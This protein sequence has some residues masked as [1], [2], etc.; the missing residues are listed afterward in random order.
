M[1][2]FHTTDP[3]SGYSDSCPVAVLKARLTVKYSIT[4]PR[5]RIRLLTRHCPT[6]GVIPLRQWIFE[7]M[8]ASSLS[9]ILWVDAIC[10]DQSN[11]KEQGEQVGMMWDIYQTADCVVIWLG[12]EG[13]DSTIAMESFARREAQTKIAAR[14][15]RARRWEDRRDISQCECPAGDFK[16]HRR[17]IGVQNL[18]GRRWFTRIWV[19]QEVAAAKSVSVVCGNKTVNGNDF[20]HEVMAVASFYGSFQ[21]LVQKIRPALELMNQSTQNLETRSSSLIELIESF[22][23]WNASKALDKVYALL[24]I[25]SDARSVPELQPD[26]TI[27]EDVLAQKLVRFAFP[28]SVINPQ[29]TRQ[30]EVVFEIEGLFLGTIGGERRCLSFRDDIESGR[31]WK[32]DTD[33]SHLPDEV[34]DSVA[35]DL[36]QDSWSIPAV[37]ERLLQEGSPVVLLRGASRP[38]VLRLHGDHYVVDML[39]TPEPVYEVFHHRKDKEK[40][41][42]VALKALAAASDRLIKLKL[43][44]DPF[45]QLCPSETSR[46]TPTINSLLTQ[47]EARIESLKDAAEIGGGQSHDCKTTG[48]FWTQSYPH[49]KDIE[50]GT[51]EDMMTLH[52]AAYHGYYGTVKLLLDSNAQVDGQHNGLNVTALHLAVAQGHTKVVRALLE[53]K[54]TVDVLDQYNWTPLSTAVDNNNYEICQ[55]LLDAGADPDS[56]KSHKYYP[57]FTCAA[58]GY[59]NIASALLKA[60]ADANAVV[61]DISSMSGATPL[62]L[63][64]EMGHNDVIEGLLAGG[65]HADA[66]MTNDTTPIHLAAT[67]GH[68]ESVKQLLDA[69]ADVSFRNR[70]GMTPLLFAAY[71]GHGETAEM[72]W[73]AGGEIYELSLAENKGYI[74]S[75]RR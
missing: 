15:V 52:K 42:P 59:A 35:S 39:A 66:R 2:I 33:K 54:A 65:A 58:K 73:H 49:E 19:L 62:H 23:T 20:Y 48:M 16:L 50:V 40:T 8:A 41:W 44:W 5:T 72:I 36:L 21:M 43:S 30:A 69:G 24:G 11:T 67:N 18:L 68:L 6:L 17:R 61:E 3:V 70:I 32:L 55:M 56:R 34:L 1:S 22:R 25:S 57:L 63:A 29:S 53:A 60:G 38:T 74:A 45:R 26:Y 10:I 64:A 7:S 14:N 47:W 4:I 37:N 13:G 28:N 75:E 51:W 9:R 12:P 27:L 71:Q 31:W 46:Y